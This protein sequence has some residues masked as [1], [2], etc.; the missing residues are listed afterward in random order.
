MS[1]FNKHKQAL[2][3]QPL[4]NNNFILKF[5]LEK[6]FIQ[7]SRN[8]FFPKMLIAV[9][10]ISLALFPMVANFDVKNIRLVVVDNDQSNYSTRLMNKATASGHFTMKGIAENY[11]AALYYIEQDKADLI[12]EIPVRFEESL[13]TQ[14][15]TQ[16]LI[17][18]NSVNGMKGGLSS[19]YMATII[20]NFT[21]ELLAEQMPAS[22]SL[23]APMIEIVP[24]YRFNPR[25]EY[26]YTMIPAILMMILAM[27]VGFLPA[28]NI[29]SE[30]EKG[31]LEQMNVTPASPFIIIL[32][33]LIPYWLMGFVVLTIGF[34]VAWLFYGMIALGSYFLIYL[35]AAVFS[36][37]FSGFGLAI[38]NYAQNF[39]Q[40]MFIM[41]FFVI[42]FIFLSGLYTPVSS[43]PEWTQTLSR[44]SPLRYTVEVLRSVFLKGSVFSDLKYHFLALCG[45]AVFF[46]GW[47][48]LGYRKTT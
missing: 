18:A 22:N 12:L 14:G 1:I 3:K 5:L 46:N 31:T 15:K 34:F 10:L 9:P 2:S 17:A 11:D 23:K 48:V 20:S 13:I 36:L 38:S 33:K 28:L 37:A 40:A 19:S 21:A 29:V 24:H 6:E 35:F 26:K 41:F 7:F 4:S 32:S 45:F 44:F 47:A 8:K 30:K 16:V 43:M 25:L 42:S 27:I 39:Q